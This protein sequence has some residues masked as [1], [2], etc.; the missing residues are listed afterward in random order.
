MQLAT[1]IDL[2]LQRV[3]LIRENVSL[4]AK[5]VHK[6]QFNLTGTQQSLRKNL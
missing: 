3:V 6:L 5:I 2:V 1:V 4:F